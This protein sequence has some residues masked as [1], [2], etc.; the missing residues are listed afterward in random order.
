MEKFLSMRQIFILTAV[1]LA[2]VFT[3]CKTGG[4]QEK[5]ELSTGIW[6]AV[7][8]IQ[9][10]KLPFNFQVT[11]NKEGHYQFTLINAEEKITLNDYT[12]HG[13][14]I[15]IPMHIFD[16][17]LKAVCTKT[18]MK[19]IWKKKYLADYEIP[20]EARHNEKFRFKNTDAKTGTDFGGKWEVTFYEDGVESTAI[21]IFDQKNRNVKGTFLTTTGDYRYLEGIQK[22][23]Q[24]LLSCFD[25]E[26]AFLFKAQLRKDGTLEGMFWSGRHWQQKWTAERNE[27]ISLPDPYELTFLKKGFD[28]L[29][30]SFPNTEGEIVSLEDPRYENQV[31]IVQILG[32]WCPNC[33]D[34]TA[35][36]SK[37]YRENSDKDVKIVGLAFE[38]KDDFNYAQKRINKLKERYGITYD[39]LFAGKSSKEEASR[40]LS[41]LNRVVS[42]PT[43][44]FI[45]KT[46]NVRKIHTGF[47]GPGTGKYYAQFVEEFNLFVNKLLE[48]DQE[49][50]S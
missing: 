40:K 14:T 47:N 25:G 1:A 35:F 34:E 23:E 8:S 30:F 48:E 29:S 11:T 12:W 41:M 9:D 38:R 3:G 27:N 39:I 6:R 10:Q 18:T 4:Q 5:V 32:T 31:V 42:F 33:M 16:T 36:L 13:D 44:I 19:G 28:K 17:E 37:W 46:G 15:T 2:M 50:N 20:F 21:A 45:D 24:L 22:G 43:T 26:H 7:L 49:A